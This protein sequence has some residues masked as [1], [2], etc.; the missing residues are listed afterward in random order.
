MESK[1]KFKETGCM[2]SCIEYTQ[3]HTLATAYQLRNGW[4]QP[5]IYIR[6]EPPDYKS[7]IQSVFAQA[8]GCIG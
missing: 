4:S 5:A 2:L 8:I 1:W 6:T 3:D 7:T